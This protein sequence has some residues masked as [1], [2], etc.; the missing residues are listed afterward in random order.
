MRRSPKWSKTCDRIASRRG[1]I[2]FAVSVRRQRSMR[3]AARMASPLYEPSGLK[4][5]TLRDSFSMGRYRNRFPDGGGGNRRRRWSSRTTC[6]ETRF[7][8][9][10][11]RLVA[12][13]SDLRPTAAGACVSSASG[14]ASSSIPSASPSASSGSA[15]ACDAHNPNARKASPGG[16]MTQQH[17]CIEQSSGLRRSQHQHSDTGH[18]GAFN[19]PNRQRRVPS[20][21]SHPSRSHRSG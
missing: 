12:G 6:P 7:R 4:M 3:E 9:R 14:V 8:P 10:P 16:D 15:T 2:S 18:W 1:S 19:P 11:R 21:P 20:C 5:L 17:E 13:L